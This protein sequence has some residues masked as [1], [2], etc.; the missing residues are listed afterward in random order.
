MYSFNSLSKNHKVFS[1][2]K[3]IH[4][5]LAMN[6]DGGSNTYSFTAMNKDAL[7]SS[8]IC[9][10]N[11]TPANV[12]NVYDAFINDSNKSNDNCSEE[13]ITQ[14]EGLSCGFLYLISTP[15]NSAKITTASDIAITCSCT[16]TITLATRITYTN[17]F[18]NGNDASKCV[19]I[20]NNNKTAS[21]SLPAAT[22]TKTPYYIYFSQS[23]SLY[24]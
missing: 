4:T 13:T 8:I 3:M 19:V 16:L 18:T 14:T 17:T 15:I 23:K 1:T 12:T 20:I 7:A 5:N 11:I 24:W 21:Y 6:I 22:I 9:V 10:N 2:N